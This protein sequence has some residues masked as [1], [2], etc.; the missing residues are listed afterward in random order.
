MKTRYVKSRDVKRINALIQDGYI[1]HSAFA[2][3]KT[4]TLIFVKEMPQQEIRP[5]RRDDVTN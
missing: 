3:G 4:T 5:S 1:L 2:S